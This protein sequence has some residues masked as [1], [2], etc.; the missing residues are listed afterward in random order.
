[1][2]DILEQLE[3]GAAK[4]GLAAGKSASTASTPRAS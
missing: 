2:K 3:T 1:M 4:R